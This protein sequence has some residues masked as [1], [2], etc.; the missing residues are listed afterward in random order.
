MWNYWAIKK[1]HVHK[2]GH[3]E[4]KMLKWMSG[5]SRKDKI[6]KKVIH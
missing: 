3:Y 1:Q 5:H 4:M 2:T 6:V